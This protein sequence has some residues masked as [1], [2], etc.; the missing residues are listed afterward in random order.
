MLERLRDAF[1]EPS[2]ARAERLERDLELP[3][4]T[5][6]HRV[7]LQL[8]DLFESARRGLSCNGKCA[9]TREL[10][11]ER[12]A[13]RI[14]DFDPAGTELKLAALA[15]LVEM[16]E[17]KQVSARAAKEVLDVLVTEGG[18][19]AAVV[20]AASPRRE[21]RAGGHVER[22]IAE[23]PDAVEKIRAGKARRAIG[24]V[25]RR[26]T[27]DEGPRRRRRYARTSRRAAR[28]LDGRI[29]AL[30]H[31][32]FAWIGPGTPRSPSGPPEDDAA[33]ADAV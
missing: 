26:D 3:A 19:P 21:R 8:G 22:A 30:W 1:L 9:H 31:D 13:A 29:L 28:R 5:A 11:D 12:V 32:S 27:R 25:V 4:E 14:G 2:V 23:N 16:V 10:D 7:P 6:R 15:E 24:T 18:D 20:E 17:S 33:F